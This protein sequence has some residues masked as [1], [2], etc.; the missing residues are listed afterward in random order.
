MIKQ[1]N[2]IGGCVQKGSRHL[3]AFAK[4]FLGQFVIGYIK[5]NTADIFNLSTTITN[6]L[7]SFLYPMNAPLFWFDP[8]FSDVWFVGFKGRDKNLFGRFE[9]FMDD[10]I[11]PL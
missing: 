9:I 8:V 5:K 3:F 11:F 1:Y 2:G 4:F 10:N 7:S 6:D